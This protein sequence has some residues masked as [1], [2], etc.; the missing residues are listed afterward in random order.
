MRDWFDRL[1]ERLR[2][3]AIDLSSQRINNHAFP[4]PVALDA[5]GQLRGQ[6]WV[7]YGGDFYRQA[8]SGRW[9][10]TYES[11]YVEHRPSEPVS[12]FIER[13][14]DA[15]TAAISK[16]SERLGEEA[17]T[18]RVVLVAAKP[19]PYDLARAY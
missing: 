10:S 11:W 9:R 5:L 16:R 15:A 7:V 12:V 18:E 4:L 6:A 19:R 8:A 3:E 13:S 17:D 14:I 2:A 1:P